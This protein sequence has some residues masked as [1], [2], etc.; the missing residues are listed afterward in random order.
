M[1]PR[2][3]ALVF[4]LAVSGQVN[5]F[6]SFAVPTKPDAAEACDLLI[7]ATFENR[8]KICKELCVLKSYRKQ[9]EFVKY[10]IQEASLNNLLSR[11]EQVEGL[12]SSDCDFAAFV[13]G[14]M[15]ALRCPI[16]KIKY[17]FGGMTKDQTD[18]FVIGDQFKRRALALR[19]RSHP[20][21]ER[22]VREHQD[23]YLWYD[24]LGRNIEAREQTEILSKLL[25]TTDPDV[26]HRRII[27]CSGACG[28][29]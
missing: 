14:Q 1:K 24:A 19:L 15:A 6:P 26:L 8:E 21:K 16:S 5:S 4:L 3:P 25:G 17:Q 29:G 7:A 28:K 13:L 11:F 23:M 22:R 9:N 27:G 12:S 20:Q 10:K 2:I 18:E